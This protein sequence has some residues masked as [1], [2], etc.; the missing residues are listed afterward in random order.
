[1]AI[2]WFPL[3][4]S[5]RVAAL[6]TIV[7]LL[8]GLWLGW[9]QTTKNYRGKDILDAIVTL[10]LVLPPTVLGYYL[11]IVLGRQSPL[12]RLYEWVFGQSL[13][14]TW[15]AAVVAAL[16]HSA[17]L[18]IKFSTAALE[19]VP[20]RYGKAAR[21]LGATE[22]MVFWRVS[23]PL[24]WNQIL[25]A[26]ALAFARSLGDF[27]ITMMVAGNIPGRT[28]TIS[29]AIYDAVEGGRGDVAR[30]LVLVISA[31]ALVSLTLANRLGRV[32]VGKAAH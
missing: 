19:S 7:A 15:Q 18:L 3:W 25:A 9:L 23:L 4:L 26:T 32:S 28:Q 11:L 20:R 21:S 17:P 2:D 22:W 27:G 31:V 12:G 10:P 1:M 5:L 29:V 30:V 6:S 8:A 16:L 14:F 24:A 13:V